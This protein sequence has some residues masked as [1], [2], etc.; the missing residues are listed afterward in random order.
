MRILISACLLG[1]V[2]RYDGRSKPHPPAE[3]LARE[4]QL[5]PVCPE[6]LGGLPTP[7]APSE[8]QGRRVVTAAGADVTEQY[9][10]GAE[11][12]LKLC[13]ALGCEAA[14]LK[15]R[16]P[17]CGCGRI[18]DGTFT[19]T[20]TDGWGVTAEL[21]RQNGVPVY[22]ESEI[23][24]LFGDTTEEKRLSNVENRKEGLLMRR[25]DREITDLAQIR[26][27]LSKARVVHLGLADGDKPYVVPMHYGYE[28]EGEKL[29]L[30]VHSAQ[31]G[32]K[33]DVIARNPNVFAE[34]DTGEILIPGGDDPCDYSA[35]Y[36]SVM[37]EGKA[38]VLEDPAE[39]AAALQILMKSQ[40]GKDFVITEEM[41]A[42][43]TVIKIQLD[44]FTAKSRP[45]QKKTKRH[46]GGEALLGLSNQELFSILA[47][48]RGVIAQAALHEIL[49]EY[50]AD[51]HKI[52]ADLQTMVREVLSKEE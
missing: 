7:R 48:D 47:G 11:E 21:L 35:A 8:R 22:G 27:I 45:V 52:D 32:R 6:Q 40:T 24:G 9:R 44:W 15:E 4:H 46:V 3:T 51:H 12:T 10:R 38:L 18:Y 29:V 42:P 37:G 25:K 39:K 41:A 30:Y 16:S 49:K 13:R 28:L 14:V 17:S 50:R 36:R 23:P 1:A 2:C 34:I 20:L 19:G 43:V 26:D 31:E 33:L 5:V